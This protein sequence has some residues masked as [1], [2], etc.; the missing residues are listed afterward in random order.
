V[1]FEVT[2]LSQP[3]AGCAGALASS[4]AAR[5]AEMGRIVV[6]ACLDKKVRPYLPKVWGCG[7]SN[8][9]PA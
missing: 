5:E 1:Q 8:R 7:S 4:R 3:I 6:Q 2:Q 9:A